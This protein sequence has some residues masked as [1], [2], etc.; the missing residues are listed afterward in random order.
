MKASGGAVAVVAATLIARS[1]D[2]SVWVWLALLSA[3]IALVP[4]SFA[5]HRGHPFV[6][7]WLLS[8]AAGPAA[9]LAIAMLWPQRVGLSSPG[10]GRT[11]RAL[12]A[13]TAAV[14]VLVVATT[15]LTAPSPEL[16]AGGQPG[17]PHL[18]DVGGA[19]AEEGRSTAPLQARTVQTVRL[20]YAELLSGEAG[21][22]AA[23]ETANDTARVAAA[24]HAAGLAG[25]VSQHLDE[26]AELAALHA[27]GGDVT[28]DAWLLLERY[29]AVVVQLLD[30]GSAG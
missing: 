17:P 23:H 24:A 1:G 10:R 4:A 26:L 27:A 28:A 9:W 22:D 12:T 5:A 21:S 29:P 6:R 19:A 3:A 11:D 25:E 13:G 8:A 7:W 30:P 18:P 20:A 14:G 2:P 15:L 16:A